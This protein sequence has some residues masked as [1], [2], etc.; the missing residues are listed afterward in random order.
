[1]QNWK[2][3]GYYIWWSGGIGNIH[4]PLYW[5]IAFTRSISGS[6][7]NQRTESTRIQPNE[8]LID[9]PKS[10]FN[11]LTMIAWRGSNGR[12]P[13]RGIYQEKSYGQTANLQFQSNYLRSENSR[14]ERKEFW[15]R[16]RKGPISRFL[17]ESVGVKNLG[18]QSE[19]S[20]TSITPSVNV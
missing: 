5:L 10:A 15:Q 2:I 8:E 11:V 3:F 16:F 12:C 20:K 13:N 17:G 7:Q 1:M 18:V 14:R 4:V 9:F 6:E 19:S